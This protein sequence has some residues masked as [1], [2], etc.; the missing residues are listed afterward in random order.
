MI[1]KVRLPSSML[2]ERLLQ[3]VISIM[4]MAGYKVSEPYGM[5]PRSFDIVA[6][7]GDSLLIFKVVSH[8][9]SVSEES[10]HDL[11]LVAEHFGGKPI[12]IGE[13]ARDSELERGAVYLRYGIIA[14]NAPTLYDFF[15]EEVPPLVYAQPGGLYVN[16]NG[17]LLR[18]LRERNNLSLGDLAHLLGVS[19]RT[20]SKYE[21]GMSTTL[22]IA[23]RLEE[24][25]D[26]ALVEAID[27][28]SHAPKSE[29]TYASF[30]RVAQEM[31]AD[32]QRIGMECHATVQAPFDALAYY[33]K[34]TI[35]AGYGTAQ[36]V[37]RR[38][39]LIGNISDVTGAYALCVVT[40]YT[41]PKKVGRTLIIGDKDLAGIEDASDLIGRI[42]TK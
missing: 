6:A 23:I 41:K 14:T 3:N 15:V 2:H 37:M 12:I 32:L 36:N 18:K 34:E 16:I 33:Q 19:R 22:E 4:I 11:H 25:F 21:D 30:S 17:S 24:L 29:H 9:D 28:L 10:A 8:I 5:R 7:K 13:K 38:A 31:I 20:I 39:A 1:R 35:L 42:A 27:L 26:Y 40:D